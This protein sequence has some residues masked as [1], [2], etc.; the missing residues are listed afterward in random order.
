MR[1]YLKNKQKAKGRAGAMAQ[2][3]ETL[4]STSHYHCLKK[5]KKRGT[6]RFAE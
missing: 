2:V 5:K 1:P 3:V 4:S 6:G